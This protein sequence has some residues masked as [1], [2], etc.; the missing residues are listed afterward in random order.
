[1]GKL[2]L[3][4]CAC[5]V[6]V[7]TLASACG[8]S[9]AKRAVRAGGGEGGADDGGAASTPGGAP[10]AGVDD[11]GGQGGAGA[12]TGG[13]SSAAGG[14]GGAPTLVDNLTVYV[15]SGRFAQVAALGELAADGPLYTCTDQR[16]NFPEQYVGTCLISTCT[17]S[18]TPEDVALG[19]PPARGTMTLAGGPED[20]TFPP[21][22]LG[23]VSDLFDGG[24]AMTLSAPAGDVVPAFS[25]AFTAPAPSVLGE[26]AF[27]NHPTAMTVSTASDM[28]VTWSPVA[29]AEV[30]MV[31]FSVSN[32]NGDDPNISMAL[33]CSF[34]MAAGAGVVPASLMQELPTDT[35]S[36]YSFS[37]AAQHF[38]RQVIDGFPIELRVNRQLETA[39]GIY[40]SN[41]NVT[42]E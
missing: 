37:I 4:L 42:L 28:N 9:D 6:M 7:P 32:P 27:V 14:E 1:M 10:A 5:V 34:D 16:I 38:A 29:D 13:T 26:P 2:R 24:E 25:F 36:P 22:A 3:V 21:D 23:G 11:A 31:T 17:S 41:G 40:T 15:N 30:V 18:G 39:G 12:A 33:S 8:S 20:Y 35:P 19:M